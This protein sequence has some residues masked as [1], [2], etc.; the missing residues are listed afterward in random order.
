MTV[1]KADHL[2][3]GD[4]LI[5]C[6]V[7][8]LWA[9]FKNNNA[10]DSKNSVFFC[11]PFL[12]DSQF[13]LGHFCHRFSFYLLVCCL[14]FSCC[15]Y[16]FCVS[17]MPSVPALSPCAPLAPTLVLHHSGRRRSFFFFLNFISLW[18]DWHHPWIAAFR[19]VF[20]K[21]PWMFYFILHEP[22]KKPTVCNILF[23]GSDIIITF[24]F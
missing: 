17:M 14:E 4:Y 3:I 20:H 8:C 7:P 10:Y 24:G 19:S 5:H 12:R 22:V 11:L 9:A 15:V 13:L 1:M 6:C 23:S 16:E 2:I 18:G 21:Y